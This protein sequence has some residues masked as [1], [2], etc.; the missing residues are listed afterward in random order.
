MISPRR[1][2]AGVEYLGT[3][4]CGWQ[5]QAGLPA[6]QSELER[7]LAAVADHPISVVAAG[8]TDAGVHAFQQ[9]IHFD[10]A[11]ARTP[12]AWL[13]GCNRHLP[14]DAALRWVQ[15]V[16]SDF[17][18]RYSAIQRSYRYVI[19]V[20]PGRSALTRARAAWRTRTLD[21][22]AM[23]RAAQVLMGEHDFS[24]FRDSQCQSP[25]PMRNL[26]QIE[27]R[28][29]GEFVVIDVTANAFLHHMVRNIAGSLLEV[30][31]GKQ[32]ESWIATVL[33]GKK[34]TEAG[35]TADPAGLYFIGPA[36]P[37]EFAL[38]SPPSPWFPP[39]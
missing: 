16:K 2:A 22:G 39:L 20:T 3:R 23:H 13:L 38:P 15:E 19:H 31:Q 12:Y 25:S 33:N 27:V 37:A 36:Y 10:S 34:R 21:A 9:V 29:S 18:A 1:W 26:H 32:P 7:A 8:R 17:H 6:V 24:A 11:A 35:M 14:S 5:T 4:F 30:G 28:A